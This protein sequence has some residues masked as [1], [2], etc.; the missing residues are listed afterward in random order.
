[1]NVKIVSDDFRAVES[2]I[3][4]M[5]AALERPAAGIKVVGRA[6]QNHL[7]KH[8]T[9]RNQVINKRGWKKQGFWA[10]VRDSVQLSSDANSTTIV[11]NDP[12]FLQKVFG[13]TIR[14]KQAKALAIPL[15]EEFYGVNPATFGKD[16]F[17]VIKSKQ[18]KNLGILAE[19][20]PDGSLR[21]CYVLKKQVTQKADANALPDLDEVLAVAAKAMS[22]F[23]ERELAK[24]I[25]KA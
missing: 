25:K 14:A 12:R 6:V 11:V 9:K 22:D 19:K 5:A 8:F 21:L 24:L 7:K 1:M 23:T 17:F 3:V 13:G 18:G 16:R 15:K 20:N 10:Q 4:G 2:L